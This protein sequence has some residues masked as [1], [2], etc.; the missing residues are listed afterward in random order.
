LLRIE[1]T[2][3]QLNQFNRVKPQKD[4]KDHEGIRGVVFFLLAGSRK[5]VANFLRPAAQLF[6]RCDP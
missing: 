3:V 2:E 4:T 6:A 5:L 1:A